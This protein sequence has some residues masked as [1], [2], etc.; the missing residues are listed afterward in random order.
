MG[1]ILVFSM[2]VYME[3]HFSFSRGL[4]EGTQDVLRKTHI[5]SERLVK[6]IKQAISTVKITSAIILGILAKGN[7]KNRLVKIKK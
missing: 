3:K 4:V 5:L 7:I 1:V 2:G 6:E